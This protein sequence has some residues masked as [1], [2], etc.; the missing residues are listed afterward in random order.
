MKIN[1]IKLILLLVLLIGAA[2]VRLYKLD[3]VPASLYFDEVD[4]GYQARSLI[5]TFKDYRGTWSPFFVHSVN[6]PRA[7]VNA[8]LT[9]PTTLLLEVPELQVR[10]PGAVLGVVSVFLIFS[11]ILLW[12]KSLT[13]AFITALVFALNPWQIQFSRWSHEVMPMTVLYLLGLFCFYRAFKDGPSKRQNFILLLLAVIFFGVGVYTYRPMSLYAPLT[14]LLI[15]FIYRKELWSFGWHKL[16]GLGV[17]FAAIVLPFLYVT[18]FGAKDLPRIN[19]ISVFSDQSIPVLVQRDREVD[20]D[21][22]TDASVGKKA[23]LSSFFL[24]N[25]PLSWL[26][27]FTSNYYQAFSTDF[28]FLKGDPNPRHSIGQIGELFFIDILALLSGLFFIIRNWK[29]KTYRFILGWLLISPIPDALTFDGAHHAARLFTFSTPLLVVIGLGWWQIVAGLKKYSRGKFLL[30]LI[31]ILW[32]LM[33]IFYLHRYFVHYPIDSARYF[34]YGFKQ[35]VLKISQEE[36]KY[37]QVIMV[38][39]ADPPMIYYL[40]WSGTSPKF[41]QEYGTNFSKETILGKRLDKY[42]VVDFLKEG[43]TGQKL[44]NSLRADTLYLLTQS[45]LQV[46]LRKDSL[47]EGVK[48]VDLIKFPDNEL[49]FYLVTKD[50]SINSP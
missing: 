36:S 49:S 15:V 38:P 11:L 30:G 25:K 39:T 6:D 37:K 43:I 47:P 34:G 22:M 17:I 50:E 29:V 42:K 48:L 21:N 9:I 20:S 41:V 45:E 32:F 46:D 28:L 4:T 8:Y 12:T 13:A 24:H 3:Q 14:A 23:D 27:T 33:V 40:F 1:R 31:F 35:S 19:Q 10:V 2:A 5:E 26:S 18:T 7:P 16:I 44:I